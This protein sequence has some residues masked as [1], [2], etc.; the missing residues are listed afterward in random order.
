MRAYEPFRSPSASL[1]PSLL[2]L[3]LVLSLAQS[4]GGGDQLSVASL[5]DRDRG[6]RLRRK[7][8]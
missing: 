7:D 3:S 5:N 8:G 2:R 4:G 1:A 6:R